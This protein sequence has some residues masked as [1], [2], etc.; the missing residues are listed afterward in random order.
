M[1]KRDPVLLFDDMLLAIA[2]IRTYTASLDFEA[3]LTET[4]TV[5]AVER[6]FEII[7]EAASQL[8]QSV[9]DS[10]TGIDWY[11]IISFRNRL[12]HGYFGVDYQILWYI[13]Q[14]ELAILETDIQLL[15]SNYPTTE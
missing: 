15:R 9:R 5:D 2:K 12:I 11:A 8:P 10:A 13:V 3:F 7:G 6:N 1:S 4:R 14:H